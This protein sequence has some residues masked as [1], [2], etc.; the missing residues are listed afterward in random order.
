[1]I[2][3]ST[4]PTQTLAELNN[5]RKARLARFNAAASQYQAKLDEVQRQKDRA[6]QIAA[7]EFAIANMPRKPVIKPIPAPT[8]ELPVVTRPAIE[9]ND[10]IRA[11]A[12]SFGVSREDLRGRRKTMQLVRARQ[13]AAFLIRD[14]TNLSLPRTGR[15]LGGRDHTT[16]IY[17]VERIKKEMADYTVYGLKA[18]EIRR[19]LLA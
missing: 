12:Y 10:I 7:F 15:M 2:S 5:A 16:M 13:V 14:L 8:V 6:A 19:E 1:M 18:Y 9:A 3:A 17:S 4:H 11:V